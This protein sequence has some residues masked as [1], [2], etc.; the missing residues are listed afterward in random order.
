VAGD[1]DPVPCRDDV[2][3]VV[4]K[5]LTS[6]PVGERVGIAFSGGLD[7]SVAVAWMREKGAIPCTYT[8]DL[9]Q[10]DEPDIDRCPGRAPC[11]TAPSFRASSTAAASWSRRGCRRW[12]AARST[13][14]RRQDLLQHHP[15][16]ARGHR[17]D[18]GA[19]H[20]RGRGLTSGATARPSRATTSSASTATGCW[21]TRPAH[22]Q[23]LARRRVRLRAGRARRDERLAHER[24]LPYRDS[25][26]KAYST[27]ANIWGATHEAKTLEHLDVSL[28][29][30]E[31]I[32]GVRIWDPSVAIETEDVTI[33]LRP[34]PAGRDQR[35]RPRRRSDL[36]GGQQ[37]SAA[38]TGSACPTRSRTAS[39]RPSRAASTRRPGW[40]CCTSPTSGSSTLSTTRTPSRTTTPRA[41]ASGGCCTRAAGSTRSR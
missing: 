20:A 28:E 16:R 37:P 3:L 39:S 5:V 40:R 6:L 10:Y 7:T 1:Q 11:S 36:V 8:A 23:A 17:H 32:M 29:T 24:N 38:G 34:G 33:T 31:P 27:D 41:A 14:A 15:A 12:R 18:A 2:D 4:A 22:L 35:P 30:V 25:Q 19:G 13:S 26:E 21:R 9:G